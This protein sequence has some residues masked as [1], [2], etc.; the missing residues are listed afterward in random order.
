MA[1]GQW[2]ETNKILP[3]I[4]I[5]YKTV[6]EA[7]ATVG[8]RGVVAIARKLPWGPYSKPIEIRDTLNLKDQLGFD[9][10]SDE[11]L[12]LRQI[13]LGSDLT[14]G[15]SKVLVAR[16]KEDGGVNASVTVGNLKATATFSGILG[17]DLSI[18]VTPVLGTEKENNPD[19]YYQWLVETVLKN[20]IIY[21]EVVGVYNEAGDPNN[22]EGLVQDLKGNDYIK[23]TGAGEFEPTVGAALTGGIPGDIAADAHAAFLAELEKKDFNVVIYDG[24]NTVTKSIYKSFVDR[25]C[26]DNGRYVTG[27]MSNYLSP[28]SEYIISV[29]NGVTIETGETLTPEQCTWWV[30][31][32]TAGANYFESLTYHQYPGATGVY[33]EYT[34]VELEE[35][36]SEGSFTFFKNEDNI[37]VL[38]DINTFHSFTPTK[39]RALSKNRV[40]RVI[41]Q[42]CNDLYSNYSKQYIGK[43]DVNAAGVDLVKAL[44]INYLKQ[45]QTNNGIKNF[46][47]ENDYIV[48]EF[49]I[50]SMKI[51]MYIQ[52]VDSL[53]KIYISMTI[54]G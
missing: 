53:E 34:N 30:G 16:L 49:E 32:A 36:I 28:N 50:D 20:E 38:T 3:G 46:D 39:A 29:N 45:I 31:G 21:S 37:L 4:Y 11:A 27:V 17:N 25:M 7:S 42:I 15:A 9:I 5:K 23:F 1:G 13:F 48:K 8:A 47:P 51:D 6:S 14:R 22:K 26:I 40:M 18:I 19:E 24:D 33:P 2:T 12:F 43:V 41:Y 35:R 44:G 10:A 54:Q 52:P